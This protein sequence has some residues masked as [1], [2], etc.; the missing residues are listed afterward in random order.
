MPFEQFELLAQAFHGKN[1]TLYLDIDGTLSNFHQN[2]YQAFA[3]PAIV[4]L[5]DQMIEEDP[6]SVVFVTGRPREEVVGIPKDDTIKGLLFTSTGEN[7]YEK[8]KES[9]CLICDHGQNFWI[10]A[11][12]K[13]T[14]PLTSVQNI[15][16]DQT[17]KHAVEMIKAFY[18]ANPSLQKNYELVEK[19]TG[20]YLKN[21]KSQEEGLILETAKESSFAFHWRI[22]NDQPET[23]TQFTSAV[24]QFKRDHVTGQTTD[25]ELEGNSDM[26]REF[27]PTIFDK[28]LM[29]KHCLDLPGFSE[30]TTC[31]AMG[32]SCSP[33]GTDRPF[34]EAII[35][36]GGLAFQVQ[37]PGKP[38]STIQGLTARLE[39]KKDCIIAGSIEFFKLFQENVELNRPLGLHSMGL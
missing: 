1:L 24:D 39:G 4:D 8:H 22:F 34:L 33:T 15:F 29:V 9:M 31:V 12:N 20:L 11:E 13:R 25:F 23:V 36:K 18:K 3:N 7:L 5:L 32:D 6:C 28:G 30:K 37:H 17:K 16:L 21:R 38:A 26:V 19:T 14:I 2:K 10:G 27:Y 35:N